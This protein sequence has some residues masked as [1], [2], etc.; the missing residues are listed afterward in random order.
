MIVVA[1]YFVFPA[2]FFLA[3]SF[4][5]GLGY[6]LFGV[7]FAILALTRPF[8][9]S[10]GYRSGEVSVA[11]GHAFLRIPGK[12]IMF[13]D[14]KHFRAYRLGE[15]KFWFA[16][17]GFRRGYGVELEFITVDAAEKFNRDILDLGFATEPGRSPAG[18]E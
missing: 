5:L 2:A 15:S 4:L 11:R 14:N 17:T 9:P 6:L 7:V 12:D 13:F 3:R 1:L 8:S 10:R 16:G 18:P